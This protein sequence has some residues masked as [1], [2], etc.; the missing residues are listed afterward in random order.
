MSQR[1]ARAPK[2]GG[3]RAPPRALSS[4]SSSSSSSSGVDAG[5]NKGSVWLLDYGAGNVRSVRNAISAC[6]YEVRD[7]TS[8]ESLVD[9]S[10]EKLVFPGVGSFG[11][12]MAV[13][14]DG[15]YDDALAEY[16]R[17][18]E[19]AFLGICLGLQLL[20]EESEETPG[21]Q[22]LGVIPGVVGRF[23]TKAP[24]PHI[25]WNG[26][27]QRKESGLLQGMEGEDPKVYFVHSFRAALGQGEDADGWALSSTDYGGNRF[28]SSVQ[29]GR[30]M[31]TQF[32]PEKSGRNGLRILD[33]YL[34]GRAWEGVG[35]TTTTTKDGGLAEPAGGLVVGDERPTRLAQRV[36]ACL[37]VRSNDRGDLVVTKGDQYD[38]REK[39]DGGEVRNLGKPVE[40]AGRYY[41]EGAD[42]VTFLNITAFRDCP[43]RDLPMLQVLRNASEGIFVPLTVGGGI[44]DLV[45]PDGSRYA[46]VDVAGEYFR[47]GA[48]K[49]SIGSDAVEAALAWYAGGRVNAGTTGIEQISQRY[50]AQAVVVSVDP[51]RVYVATPE[52]AG[53]H[54]EN[55][56]ALPD[57]IRGP[58]GEAY[59]WYQCT[60][61]GGRE[62]RDLDAQ[63]LAVA[64]EAL[65]AGEVLLNC[66][67]QDGTNAGF[68]TGLIDAVSKAVGI[69]VIASSGAGSPQ[70]FV[71]VFEKTGAAAALAAGIFHRR[72][73]PIADVKKTMADAGV[74][75]RL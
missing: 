61:A 71:E 72:E 69:P 11:S 65:G 74:P 9:G 33:N 23:D 2:G 16:V 31:A 28:V 15:G 40:L 13:L 27:R 56:I 24:V 49:V 73:V 41:D 45:D 47:S 37:D 43:L 42:E 66:I 32:H 46:A 70:H 8:P 17:R 51:R 12:A 59:A 63:E 58:Q 4:S 44:K 25:G 64:V 10:I 50:G 29:R 39:D 3:P 1:A 30:V 68:D 6:G 21:V 57:H 26:V 18:G 34:S 55:V 35:T 67:D 48:D 38:V 62:T 7:V 19:G 20:F 60:V 14:R 22:G 75:T 5:A 36:I 54:A 53:R 52:D